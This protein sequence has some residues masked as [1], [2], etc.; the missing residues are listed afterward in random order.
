ME[1]SKIPATVRKRMVRK[2]RDA[3]GTKKSKD[4]TKNPWYEKSTNGTKRLRYEK[5]MVQKVWFPT[6]AA[7]KGLVIR[8]DQSAQHL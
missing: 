3:N 7:V 1:I 5:S 2:V 8:L 4:G 6:R